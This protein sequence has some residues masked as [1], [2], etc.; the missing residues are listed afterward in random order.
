[1]PV[2]G[3]LLEGRSHVDESLLTGE[4]LPVARQPGD[5]LAGGAV[6][7]EGL[8]LLRTTAVGAETQLARIVRMVESA[9]ARKA[10]IQ[11]LVDRVSAVFVPVVVGLALLTAVGW[12]LAR[13]RRRPSRPREPRSPRCGSE[14]R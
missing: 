1:M 3:L 13:R 8:L 2:D 11:R 6:N 9:Q 7:G 12:W 10:P 4:S 5:R 14:P